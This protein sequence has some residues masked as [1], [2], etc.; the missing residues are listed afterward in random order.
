MVILSPLLG[1]LIATIIM[2]VYLAIKN[3]FTDFFSIIEILPLIFIVFSMFSYFFS[4][5]IG[6]YL[7]N[8]KN[9]WMWSDGYF[10]FVSF[11]YSTIIGFAFFGINLYLEENLI[12]AII[13]LCCFSLGGLFNASFYIGI[14]KELKKNEQK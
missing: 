8:K 4:I 5:P 1:S 12:K 14:I 11:I 7:I 9:I 10:M 6:K 13:I 3:S 2:I